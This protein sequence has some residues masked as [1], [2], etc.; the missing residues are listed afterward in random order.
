MWLIWEYI[1]KCILNIILYTR[2]TSS[3][4]RRGQNK[5]WVRYTYTV[6]SKGLEMVRSPTHHLICVHVSL[7]KVNL[8]TCSSRFNYYMSLLLF[9]FSHYYLSPI[10]FIWLPMCLCVEDWFPRHRSGW[11]VPSLT[12]TVA[13][14]HTPSSVL[15]YS[16]YLEHIYTKYL[17]SL[18]IFRPLF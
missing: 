12:S 9:C 6:Y 18:H 14:T 15:L 11:R 8:E 2:Q 1:Y 17:H 13:Q 3:H 7:C 10:L 5:E 16:S 4:K